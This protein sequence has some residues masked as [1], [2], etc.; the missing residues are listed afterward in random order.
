M[1]D[2]DRFICGFCKHQ[3]FDETR[4]TL[5]TLEETTF[6]TKATGD[7]AMFACGT[8]GAILGFVSIAKPVNP[9]QG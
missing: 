6:Q 5:E 2:H 9:A 8:C 3:A 1:S 7:V 4:E